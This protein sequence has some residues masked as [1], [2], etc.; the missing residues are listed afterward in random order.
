[1]QRCLLLIFYS[2][3]LLRLESRMKCKD[4]KWVSSMQLWLPFVLLAKTKLS[5]CGASRPHAVH[6]CGGHGPRSAG[7][8]SDRAGPAA[9]QRRGEC[10][11]DRRPLTLLE[12]PAS[13]REGEPGGPEPL[14]ARP[15]RPLLE[16]GPSDWGQQGEPRARRTSGSGGAGAGQSRA[17][18]TDSSFSSVG[19]SFALK[20]SYFYLF[21]W[22]RKKKNHIFSCFLKCESLSSISPHWIGLSISFHFIYVTVYWQWSGFYS[23][24][25]TFTFLTHGLEF[26]NLTCRW[27]TSPSSGLRVCLRGAGRRENRRRAEEDGRHPEEHR[28]HCSPLVERPQCPASPLTEQTT[29]GGGCC[30]CCTCG[31]IPGR[32]CIHHQ[33]TWHS[34]TFR[35]P[36]VILQE[37]DHRAVVLRILIFLLD[38]SCCEKML[39]ILKKQE[40]K[41][42]CLDWTESWMWVKM[43]L[44]SISDQLRLSMK[45]FDNNNNKKKKNDMLLQLWF[46][47]FRESPVKKD[48]YCPGK[49]HGANLFWNMFPDFLLFALVSPPC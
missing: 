6:R 27:S 22:K 10:R 36:R 21:F 41:T 2:A 31:R 19:K 5:P 12:E 42:L 48:E 46:T 45:N 20:I 24:P 11:A 7:G 32:K 49:L 8:L 23:V 38:E 15:Q 28:R 40:K 1:M 29:S 39:W 47:H 25:S 9:R 18:E 37:T 34:N 35:W 33:L 43:C 14:G 4:L 17:G 30:C 13:S 26:K 3:T 44:K 16:S